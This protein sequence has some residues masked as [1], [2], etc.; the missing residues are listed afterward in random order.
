LRNGLRRFESYSFTQNISYMRFTSHQNRLAFSVALLALAFP[1][2]A[3]TA[4]AASKP[5]VALVMKSL[6]NEFFQTMEK[7]ARDYQAQHSSEFAL[8]S[9]LWPRSGLPAGKAR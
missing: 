6:A 8:I 5:Q 1:I 4:Q 9:V 7:G 2:A 3:V